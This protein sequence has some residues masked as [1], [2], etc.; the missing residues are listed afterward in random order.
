MA[1]GFLFYSA[2]P[3][4]G[5]LK[6][7]GTENLNFFGPKWLNLLPFQDPKKSRFSGPT[8]SNGPCNGFACIK[9]LS[10]APYKQFMV[11]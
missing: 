3:L 6:G 4:L 2:N 5:A 8:P 10:P 7:V 1:L 9:S 11:H